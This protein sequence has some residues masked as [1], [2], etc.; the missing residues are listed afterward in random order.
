MILLVDDDRAICASLALLLQRA[1]YGVQMIHHPKDLDAALLARTSGF[2]KT[3]YALIILDMNFTITTTGKAGLDTLKEIKRLS[4][5]LP[6]ILVTGWATVQLAVEGMKLGASDFIAKPWDNKHLLASVKTLLALDGHATKQPFNQ[7]T[8]HPNHQTTKQPHKDLIGS[9]PRFLKAVELA[10]RVA[11]TDASVLLTG[12]SGTGKEVFA[13]AIHASS[14]RAEKP[15]VAVNL[16]GI[17]ESLFESEL[18]G[19]KAGAFTDARTD[20]QGRFALAEGGTLFLDEIGDLPFASQVKLLRVLQEHTYEVLGESRPRKTDVRVIS[21]TNKDLRA[22]IAAGTFRE[23][24]FYRVN[25]IELELPPL[26]DRGRD[27]VTLARQVLAKAAQRYNRLELVL[28][29]D[30]ET[31]LMQQVWPGN[32]R[33][34]RNVLERCALL[35]EGS[36]S[37]KQLDQQLG[38]N[39]APAL[40]ATLDELTLEQLE[41]TAIERAL[42]RNEGQIAGAAR[43]LGITRSALYRRVEKWGL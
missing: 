32:V 25:L 20:R 33:Q 35:F 11:P 22:M 27:V 37:A 9:S 31:W 30:A 7:N 38:G 13:E 2:A 8:N 41:R 14:P 26:R 28:S 3:E 4:P 23:D 19:H 39:S 17:P 29:P 6:V 21:A 34:L 24:L 1:G 12:E 36:L 40:G 16:G 43:D 18:F 10:Q 5:K 42:A 15:F